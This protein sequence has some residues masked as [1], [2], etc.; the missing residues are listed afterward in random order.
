MIVPPGRRLRPFAP[1]WW[2]RGGHRQTALG[3]WY[4]R[5]LRWRLPTEDLIADVGD[6][7]RLLLRAS[8]QPGERA[9]R[10]AVL[11]VHGLGGWDLAAY[12]LATGAYAHAMG[13][14]V[15][16]M[17]NAARGIPPAYTPARKSRP[18]PRTRRGHSAVAEHTRA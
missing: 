11:L 6:G 2:T 5:R 13:W 10:P 18:G 1:P 15:V 4:R 9:Q 3:F 17:N 12:G 16:R 14:H 8:W 7:V